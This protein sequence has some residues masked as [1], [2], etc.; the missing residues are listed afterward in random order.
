MSFGSTVSMWFG[1]NV[2]HLT[3]NLILNLKRKIY[4]FMWY[5]YH[6]KLNFVSC[7][8]FTRIY[9]ILLLFYHKLNVLIFVIYFVLM[10]NQLLNVITNYYNFEIITRFDIRE[11]QV[12][13]TIHIVKI[14][15]Y[16][17]LNKLEE[18]YPQMKNEINQ[19]HKSYT[20]DLN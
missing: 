13:P 11:T 20:D 6:T 10:S 15:S 16:T 4:Q 12:F 3:I 17:E 5:L 18:I 2:F 14:L 19:K 7:R 8:L 9:K 1:V